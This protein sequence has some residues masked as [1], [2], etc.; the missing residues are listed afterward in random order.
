MRGISTF[1]IGQR[2][3]SAFRSNLPLSAGMGELSGGYRQKG[4]NADA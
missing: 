2:G 1:M 3:P 4:Q